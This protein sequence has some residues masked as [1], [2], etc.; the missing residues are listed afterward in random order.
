MQLYRYL[1]S[2]L[3][4]NVITS[5][6]ADGMC[7]L[8]SVVLQ[9][10]LDSRFSVWDITAVLLQWLSLRKPEWAAYV[11]DEYMDE[12]IVWEKRQ[13]TIENAQNMGTFIVAAGGREQDAVMFNQICYRLGGARD[14]NV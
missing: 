12:R 5:A 8:R 11:D 1:T 4:D 2:N 14:S 3:G 6:P 9:L 13:Q 10:K 7:F